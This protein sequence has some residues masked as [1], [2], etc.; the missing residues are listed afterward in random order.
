MEAISSAA[1][2][3]RPAAQVNPNVVLAPRGGRAVHDRARR[4][5]RERRLA[6]DPGRPRFLPA[7]PAVGAER[8]HPRLRRVPAAGRAPRRPP[9]APAAVHGRDGAVRRG[10]THLRCGAVGGDAAGC[11]R[12]PGTGWRHGLA[13]GAVDHPDH[14]RRGHGTQPRTGGVGRHRRSRRC[15]GPAPRRR[16]RRS[17]ELAM[18]LL[19][20]R[21]H[22]RPALGR[23]TATHPGE[24]FAGRGGR[25]RRR[26]RHLHH[27]G[28]RRARVR[29]DRGRVVG[30][31]VR[32]HAGWLRR[33]RRC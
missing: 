31:D 33:L 23:G 28:D 19:R 13:R 10:V 20:E 7:E 30:L 25:L 1:P 12:P 4:D 9:R 21:P 24:P 22:R 27:A 26:G 17:A 2:A 11:A 14:L 5:D 18:D 3:S 32:P 6:D 15:D 16:D 8:L 29:T